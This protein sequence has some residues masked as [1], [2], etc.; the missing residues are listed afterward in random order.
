MSQVDDVLSGYTESPII[1]DS[2]MGE[3]LEAA[4]FEFF[5]AALP[6]DPGVSSPVPVLDDEILGH[7]QAPEYQK[8]NSTGEVQIA[9]NTKVKPGPPVP[10][11][12]GLPHGQLEP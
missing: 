8:D 4:E 7:P 2:D 3:T 12:L 11:S 1:L 6:Q 9:S 5:N 10:S